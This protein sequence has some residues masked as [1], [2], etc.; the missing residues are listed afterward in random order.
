MSINEKVLKYE[1]FLNEKLRTDLREVHAQRDQIYKQ[2]SQY[3]QL[4][5]LIETIKGQQAEQN[6][7]TGTKKKTKVQCDVKMKMDLGCNF[8]VQAAVP[9]CSRLYVLVGYG[10]YLEMTLDEALT[11]VE[12]KMDVLK[13]KSQM[14]S[15]DSAKIKAH[16]KL[17]MEGLRELQN[18]DFDNRAPKID[19]F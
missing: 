15:K 14:F 10:Y 11:F 18:L 8:Y 4:K 1:E 12:K 3:M 19:F 6:G 2:I 9:D 7:S 5:R 13:M 17:V 16:I